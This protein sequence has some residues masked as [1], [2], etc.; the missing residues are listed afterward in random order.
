MSNTISI[1]DLAAE[2]RRLAESMP[3]RFAICSY[4]RDEGGELVPNCI[5]GQAAYNL[6]VSL[7]DLYRVNTCGIRYMS[8]DGNRPEW[9]SVGED[10]DVHVRWLGYLQGAQDSNESW[11]AALRIADRRTVMNQFGI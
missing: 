6:G 5:V 7:D 8:I 11:G 2:A 3:E 4:T 1:R 10:D 9:L